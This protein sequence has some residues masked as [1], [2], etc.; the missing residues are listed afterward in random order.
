MIVQPK[1]YIQFVEEYVDILVHG[2]VVQSV[3]AGVELMLINSHLKYHLL[4]FLQ[5]GNISSMY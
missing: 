2:I 1:I 5:S 3:K 4:Y